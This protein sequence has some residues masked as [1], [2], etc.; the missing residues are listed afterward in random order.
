MFTPLLL[1]GNKCFSLC[2][3]LLLFYCE[4]KKI[5]EKILSIVEV[6]T[7]GFLTLNHSL[8][9]MSERASSLLRDLVEE[10]SLKIVA[11]CLCHHPWLALGST[12]WYR[13]LPEHHWES[14]AAQGPS[15]PRPLGISQRNGHASINLWLTLH[16]T[17]SD[18]IYG[19]TKLVSYSEVER[20]WLLDGFW[21]AF[22]TSFGAALW[23]RDK[24]KCYLQRKK[25]ISATV[26]KQRGCDV[27]TEA[28]KTGQ[29]QGQ[30]KQTGFC[31]RRRTSS[32]PSGNIWNCKRTAVL[33]V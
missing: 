29:E 32:I 31:W 6:K 22:W 14:V 23:N 16:E 1:H 13:P 33:Q 5:I 10:S 20:S 26:L 28:R 9:R 11:K 19:S 3:N 18:F 15:P 27:L 17:G 24:E 12:A 2:S 7:I 30:V 8:Q 4:K 25:V 21:C